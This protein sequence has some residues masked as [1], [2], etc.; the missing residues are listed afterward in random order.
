[1]KG[2]LIILWIVCGN[3]NYLLKFVVFFDWLSKIRFLLPI[4]C[5]E[6]VGL[7]FYH[8]FF[9]LI[10]SWWII[11]FLLTFFLFDFWCAFNT[12]NIHKV[13]LQ[14]TSISD[15][16]DSALQLSRLDRRFAFYVLAMVFWVR[17]NER[18]MMIF[19]NHSVLSLILLFLKWQFFLYIW[20]GTNSSMDQMYRDESILIIVTD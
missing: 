8:V 6:K 3:W 11:Y 2:V 18:N 13:K 10:M 16:W 14:L 17:W 12:Y 19:S 1:M 9:A 15:L 4:I 7:V 20:T 5:A